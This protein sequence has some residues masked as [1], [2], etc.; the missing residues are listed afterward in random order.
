MGVKRPGREADRSPS[1]NVEVKNGAA[2]PPLQSHTSSWGAFKVSYKMSL[3]RQ[4]NNIRI[5]MTPLMKWVK[6]KQLLPLHH[7]LRRTHPFA[8]TH[9]CH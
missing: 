6:Q 7:L 4:L 9:A 1:F 2:V 3:G 5:N 8:G